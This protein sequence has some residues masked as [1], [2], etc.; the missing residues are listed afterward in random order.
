M[1]SAYFKVDSLESEQTP[2]SNFKRGYLP[3]NLN[4]KT[5]KTEK[6]NKSDQR[7]LLWGTS[8]MKKANTS[9]TETFW[10]PKMITLHEEQLHLK[11]GR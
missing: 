7:H 1:S 11:V 10:I 4:D 2:M 3:N 5:G 6:D 9:S 8:K